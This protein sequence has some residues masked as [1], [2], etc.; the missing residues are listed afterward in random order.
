MNLLTHR[1][2]TS[3]SVIQH[4]NVESVYGGADIDAAYVIYHPIAN[5]D[6]PDTSGKKNSIQSVEEYARPVLTIYK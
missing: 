4:T 2:W 5:D 6:Y 1:Y 3:T